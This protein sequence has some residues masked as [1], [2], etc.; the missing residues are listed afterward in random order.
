VA[1]AG[2]VRY[3]FRRERGRPNRAESDR[4]IVG[5]LSLHDSLPIGASGVARELEV[6]RTC[7]RARGRVRQR[8]GSGNYSV[9]VAGR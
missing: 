4:R 9:R 3:D 7:G 2:I 1:Q 8:A 5:A 6:L